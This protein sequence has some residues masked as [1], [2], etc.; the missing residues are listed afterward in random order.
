[1]EWVAYFCCA[2]HVLGVAG[3]EA[4]LLLLL[5]LALVRVLGV[6]GRHFGGTL[7]RW[8]CMVFAGWVVC[9]SMEPEMFVVVEES[10][11]GRFGRL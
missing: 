9:I 6:V 8:Y 10:R 5:L 1:M 2:F 7:G 4:W 11:S 3:H